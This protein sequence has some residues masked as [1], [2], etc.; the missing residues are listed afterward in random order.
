[1]RGFGRD[2]AVWG[3]AQCFGVRWCFRVRCGGLERDAARRVATNA[4]PRQHDHAGHYHRDGRY[5][6]GC[7]HMVDMWAGESSRKPRRPRPYS[8]HCGEEVAEYAAPTIIYAH[9][10]IYGKAERQITTQHAAS[11][12]PPRNGRIGFKPRYSK[13]ETAEKCPYGSIFYG[14]G[15]SPPPCNEGRFNQA[16]A[17]IRRP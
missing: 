11:L 9:A 5:S 16:L 3:A 17:I 13:R 4:R 7:A 12:R 8:R 1:M 10:G 2:A 14:E 6:P 15:F